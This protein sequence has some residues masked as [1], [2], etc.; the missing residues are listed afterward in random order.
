MDT[1][2]ILNRFTFH[3]ATPETAIIYEENRAFARD[4]ALWL[5]DMLPESRE[6]AL[7]LTHLDE[8]V[9]WANASIARN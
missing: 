1:Q 8:V 3:A 4:F 7:A 2:E 5:N 9:F 6:K